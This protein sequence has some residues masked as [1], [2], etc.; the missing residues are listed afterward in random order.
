MDPIR[1][2]ANTTSGSIDHSS[3]EEYRAAILKNASTVP[4][5]LTQLMN[6]L[7]AWES[8][9]ACAMVELLE[10]EGYLSLHHS[11]GPFFQHR[12]YVAAKYD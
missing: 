12:Y 9:S 8:R 11:E 6:G 7:G 1:L 5:N 3:D 10:R 4:K 2:L